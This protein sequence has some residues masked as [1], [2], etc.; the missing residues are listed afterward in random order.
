MLKI[1]MHSKDLEIPSKTHVREILTSP[2]LFRYNSH[3]FIL[4][5]VKYMINA[6]Q[7]LMEFLVEFISKED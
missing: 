7:F 4:N 5:L 2:K 1:E 3:H 6:E